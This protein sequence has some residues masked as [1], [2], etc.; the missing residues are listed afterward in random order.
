M[1]KVRYP[2]IYYFNFKPYFFNFKLLKFD[3]L[4][5]PSN[6]EFQIERLSFGKENLSL[7]F[8]E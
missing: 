5:V 4:F 2:M 3:F 6:N 1:I 8:K 7:T